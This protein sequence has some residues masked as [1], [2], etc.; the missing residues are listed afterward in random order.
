VP[1]LT[2]GVDPY[3][4][5]RQLMGEFSLCL[6]LSL[7]IQESPEGCVQFWTTFDGRSTRFWR[8]T[9]QLNDTFWLRLRLTP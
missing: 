6:P 2:V 9:E 3:E 1:L 7:C 4:F 5:A 8:Y